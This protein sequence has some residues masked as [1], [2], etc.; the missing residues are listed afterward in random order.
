MF[1]AKKIGTQMDAVITGVEDFGLFAQGVELP[2]EGLVH[3]DSLADDFYRFDRNTHSLAGYRSGNR[4]RL[5]DVIR[6]EVAHVDVDRRELDFRVVKKVGHAGG[7]TNPKRQRG[8]GE[9]GQRSEVRGQEAGNRGQRTED[10]RARPGGKG[11]R[12]RASD[13]RDRTKSHGR[14][15]KSRPGKRERQAKR[16]DR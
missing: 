4:Y 6:V 9:R 1:L 16:K 10:R 11:N 12:S 8:S 15:R 7:H 3:V 14:R 13:G 2:A 5:G